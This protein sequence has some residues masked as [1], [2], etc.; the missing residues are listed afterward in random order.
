MLRFTFVVLIACMIFACANTPGNNPNHPATDSM[1]NGDTIFRFNPLSDRAKQYYGNEIAPQY[2]KLLAQRGFNG[3]ILMAKNGEIVFENYRGLINMATK[4]PITASTPFHLASISKTF[5][6]M[7]VLHLWEQG[8]LSLEDTLQKYFPSF[9]YHNITIKDLLD[10]RSG[11][12]NYVHFM[13]GTVTQVTYTRNKKGRMVRRVRVV[14]SVPVPKDLVTNADVLRYIIEKR[15]PI[16]ASPNR[17][18]NYC[19]TN[20]ALLA[21]IVEQITNQPFPQYM[22]DSVFTPLGLKNTYVFSIKDTGH[23]TPSYEYNGRPFRLEKLDCV[24]GDKNVYSTVRDLFEWD[25]A[26]YRG[27]F[28]SLKTLQVAFQPYSNE[29]RSQHNYG[30]GWHL[31]INP[32]DPTIIYHNGWWHG[33]NTVFKRL[34][35]DTATVIILGNK[36]NRNIYAAGKMSSVFTGHADT[37]N[38]VEVGGE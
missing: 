28:V 36:F 4:E 12:G 3:S 21:L 25:K 16:L 23:Y 11:L 10:H 18:F 8:R 38:L 32:P 29:R 14:K 24:Y 37:S 26:L 17:I 6:A 15:P 34:V 20:Y 13:D 19:N 22:K 31:L 9:P 2:Q 5:T 7:T 35:A 27:S 1:T 33:N 30:L